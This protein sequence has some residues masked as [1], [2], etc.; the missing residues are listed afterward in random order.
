MGMISSMNRE[1]NA[2]FLDVGGK[3]RRKQTSMKNYRKDR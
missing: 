1:K 3:A 2:Y